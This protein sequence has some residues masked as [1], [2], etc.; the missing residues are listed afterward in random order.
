LKKREVAAVENEKP[1][2]ILGS[3]YLLACNN[4]P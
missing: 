4:T 2:K 3:H 1:I